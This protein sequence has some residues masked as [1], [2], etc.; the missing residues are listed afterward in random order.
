MTK[1]NSSADAGLVTA[2]TRAGLAS[3]PTDYGKVFTEMS[4][5]YDNT[6]RKTADMWKAV[7]T[8]AVGSYLGVKKAQRAKMEGPGGLENLA[9]GENLIKQVKGFGKELWGTRKLD[10]GWFGEQ[11]KAARVEITKRKDAVYAFAQSNVAGEQSLYNM[12]NGSTGKSGK[13]TA[14]TINV[15]ATGSYPMEVA[16]AYAQSQTGG[17]T[18]LGNYFVPEPDVNG[19][20]A[21]TLYNDENL[22]NY[23]A[24]S[25]KEN[26]FV[27]NPDSVLGPE[28]EDIKLPKPN[29]KPV[30]GDN[31]KKIRYTIADINGMMTQVD[32]K[33]KE[34]LNGIYGK[35]MQSGTANGGSVELNNYQQNE[36]SDAMDS[37]SRKRTAWFQKTK[38]GEDS[39]SFYGEVTSGTVTAANLFGQVSR[40]A[41]DGE[42][43]LQAQGPLKDIDG[44][45]DGVKGIQK[46]DFEN[47]DNYEA[48]TMAMFNQGN[49]NYDP[50]F[51]AGVFKQY[52]E[53]KLIDIKDHAWSRSTKNPVNK[54]GYVAPTEFNSLLAN[55]VPLKSIKPG[56][57]Y[58]GGKNTA[59]DGTMRA[60]FDLVSKALHTRSSIGR[61]KNKISWDEEKQSYFKGGMVIPDK[62]TLFTEVIR[63]H[64]KQRK[65]NKEEIGLEYGKLT[66]MFQ[67]SNYFTS[68]PEWDGSSYRLYPNLK[69][70][71]N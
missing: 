8:I 17:T 12:F 41:A 49:A 22:I 53:K 50:D 63:T 70:N 13:K 10:G 15:E 32:P 33:M 18:D 30:I 7:G 27:I 28:I 71:N 4:A 48:L 19:K 39:K 40:H 58:T 20:M 16:N 3:A 57:M 65:E 62:R 5:Y 68:I 55:H 67:M 6:M 54:P 69:T 52:M 9:N 29:G 31:G 37:I 51:T 56:N 42:T 34:L 43:T 36:M 2:A 60:T 61:G 14:P 21:W 25:V 46:K 59:M 35:A 38:Y 1:L 24:K 64:Y 66:D 47:S 11:A 44:M 23:E 45:S 26:P